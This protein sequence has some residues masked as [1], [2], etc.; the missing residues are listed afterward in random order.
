[1]LSDDTFGPYR[2][3]GTLGEGGMGDVYR[4]T[5]STCLTNF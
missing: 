4:A 5:L 1:M 2:I 3:V